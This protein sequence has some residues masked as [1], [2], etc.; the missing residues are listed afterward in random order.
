MSNTNSDKVQSLNKLKPINEGA[1]P[2]PT[3]K[4]PVPPPKNPPPKASK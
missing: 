2:G 1:A 3:Y 4:I